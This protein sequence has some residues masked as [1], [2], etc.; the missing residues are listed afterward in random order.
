MTVGG[1]REQLAERL[2]G[3][4]LTRMHLWGLAPG[5]R[6]PGIRELARELGED[7]RTV[8]EAYRQLESEGLVE[9]R[10]RSGVYA[11]APPRQAGDL[12]M[13][14]AQWLVHVFTQARQRRLRLE[15][16]PALFDRASAA[17]RL[18]CACV[19]SSED[20]MIAYTWELE[21][22]YGLHAVPVYLSGDSDDPAGLADVLH[23]AD[24]AVTTRYHARAVQSAAEAVGVPL[25]LIAVDPD[26]ARDVAQLLSERL[27]HEPVTMIVA[28]RRFLARLRRI[29]EEFLPTANRI[30]YVLADDA[31]ALARLNPAE[32]VIITR[33]ARARLG[34]R[35]PQAW[36]LHAPLFAP[37]TVRELCTE[38]VR[39][40]LE[41]NVDAS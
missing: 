32:R 30:R 17:R 31:G 2:R 24:L 36:L 23:G 33:A 5:D 19:E 7:H 1:K 18:R 38:I 20:Q 29:A 34:R 8:A 9:V 12:P 27:Q 15:E 22:S 35:A 3:R 28:D 13:E 41:S 16:L 10:G 14:T 40:N 4:I 25:V 21:N 39:L 6:L 37:E 11:A 26:A